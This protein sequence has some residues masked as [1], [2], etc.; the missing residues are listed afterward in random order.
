MAT[1]MIRD[2]KTTN[3]S[4][5][6][7]RRIAEHSGNTSKQGAPQMYSGGFAAEWDVNDSHLILGFSEEDGSNLSVSGTAQTLTQ[8]SVPYQASASVI[9][10]G[11]KFNDGRIGIALGV[12]STVFKGQVGPAQLAAN[13]T[14]GG[15]NDLVK[16]SDGHWYVDQADAA[17]IVLITAIDTIDP[18]GCY[19]TLVPAMLQQPA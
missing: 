11:V 14:I 9:P 18:R 2:V 3:D 15:T 5:P 10:P 13:L 4:Q 1:A 8:G 12:P 7:V 6:V 19:F 17:A 16:D